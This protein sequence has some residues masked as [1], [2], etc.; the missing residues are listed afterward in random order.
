[1]I[2]K[3]KSKNIIKSSKQCTDYLEAKEK[4]N[5]PL[6]NQKDHRLRNNH[7]PR[8]SILVNSLKKWVPNANNSRTQL[9]VSI[10]KYQFFTKRRKTQED[11]LKE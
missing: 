9:M 6:K 10:K 3:I 8:K 11:L 1:M 2:I 5:H 4:S 7:L